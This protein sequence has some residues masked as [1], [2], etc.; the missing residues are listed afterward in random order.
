MSRFIKYVFPAAT[1]NE[2]CKRQSKT[3]LEGKLDLNGTLANEIN[4]AVPFNVHGYCRTVTFTSD[5]D[6]S[7]VTFTVYGTQN[8]ISV[9]EDIAGPNATTV[10][11]LVVFDVITD[12]TFTGADANHVSV[13]A[14]FN[15]YFYPLTIDPFLSP[16]N[17][18]L[19]VTNGGFTGGD[20]ATFD[21]Y[22]MQN[23][24]Q[25]GHTYDENVT[26]LSLFFIVQEKETDFV[27]PISGSFSPYIPAFSGLVIRITGSVATINTPITLTYNQT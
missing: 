13:G 1:G 27:F 23:T 7:G 22:G 14:G 17:Y 26:N 19:L 21:L 18:N 10:Y 11:G 4:S 3:K 8:G 12:I 16:I 15:G 5:D 6:L 2:I 20:V 25:N 24:L 9:I